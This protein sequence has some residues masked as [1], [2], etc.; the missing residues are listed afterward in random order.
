M[1]LHCNNC[2]RKLHPAYIFC[3]FCGEEAPMRTI[4]GEI[5]EEKIKNPIFCPHCKKEN[6]ENALFCS[7]CGNDIYNRP[8]SEFQYCPYCGEKNRSNARHCF[9]CVNKFNDW[10][11]KKG[12]IAD[13]LGISGEL[14]LYEK[15]NKI[16]YHF[17]FDGKITIGKD[18]KNKISIPCD[19]ISKQHC[20]FDIK[21][22]KFVD[23]DST[24]GSFINRSDKNVKEKKFSGID[25]F[26][27]AGA[28]TFSVI[29]SGSFFAFRL[30][31]V[32]DEKSCKEVGDI[33]RINS[34]RN[35][36]FILINGNDKIFIRKQDGRIIANPEKINEFYSIEIQDRKFYYS[37]ISKNIEDEL[38]LKDRN[39]LP[40]NWEMFEKEV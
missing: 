40:V 26:N 11:D 35:H 5:S 28:F 20:E 37:E 4:V 10:Y 22:Q 9:N 7:S 16:H 18:E 8:K 31:A 39:I 25:E 38:I 12:K 6:L 32:I 14:S 17:F 36:Y 19:W 34:L 21:K 29:K 13:K 15:M 2:G 3:P 24:N 23:L 27:I 1:I 30:S 33:Q